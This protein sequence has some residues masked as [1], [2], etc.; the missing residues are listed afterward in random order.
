MKKFSLILMAAL[1]FTFFSCDNSD[2]VEEIKADSNVELNT[3][4]ATVVETEEASEAV[5]EVA[6]YE[7]DL[8]SFMESE[9]TEATGTKSGDSNRYGQLFKQWNRYKGN[10]MPDISIEFGEDGKFPMTIT[11]EYDSTELNSGK[12]IDGLISIVM[13]AAPWS[14]G[15]VREISM[16]LMIDSVAIEGT[17]RVEFTGEQ[18]VSKKWEI[19]SQITFTYPDGTE[20]F[21]SAERTR[22]WISGLDT[23]W[24]LSDDKVQITGSVTCVDTEQNEYSK[25]IDPENP[26]IRIGTCR[27][28]VQGIVIFSQNGE[29]FARL[30]YGNGECD[31]IA[32]Y[33]YINQDGEQVTEEIVIGKC[34]RKRNSA[35]N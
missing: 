19:T 22:E 34:T 33:T 7:V 23:K 1:A 32:T 17:K 31:D 6:D 13:D 8:F 30:D 35:N 16:D 25:L 27:L 28:I 9:Y 5:M 29:E 14:D 15:A 18:G 24:D 20:L 12:I 4:V 3:T 10:E 21:R 2:D 11:I 26:L